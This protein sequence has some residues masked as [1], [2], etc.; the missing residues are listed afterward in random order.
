MTRFWPTFRM[1]V[2]AA[3]VA[4]CVACAS[5]GEIESAVRATCAPD[6]GYRHHAVEREAKGE[7]WRRMWL[8]F[9]NDRWPSADA[10][11]GI[12]SLSVIGDARVAPALSRAVFEARNGQEPQIVSALLDAA[13]DLTAHHQAHS[14][15]ELL[16]L[17]KVL[18]SLF[19]D[20]SVSL[21]AYTVVGQIDLPAA[22]AVLHQELS[23]DDIDRRASALW[24]LG[25]QADGTAIAAARGLVTDSMWQSP[26]RVEKLAFFLL[27][28][29]PST[30]AEGA[31][32][33]DRLSGAGQA[34]IGRRAVA[35]VCERAQWRPA[36]SEQITAHRRALE[37]EL[38]QRSIAW[39]DVPVMASGQCS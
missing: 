29:D 4:G 8:R 18:P 39:R 3:L 35:F 13:Y 28:V 26:N 23:S 7:D 11:C 1:Q 30:L 38:D 32:L 5:R 9:A 2:H 20:A 27:T 25:I 15:P 21:G 36:E 34:T 37:S 19:P 17:L 33:L 14:S 12:Q 24:A 6:E 10:W 16:P 22:R 31:V